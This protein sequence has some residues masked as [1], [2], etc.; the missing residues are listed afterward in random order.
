MKKLPKL[1]NNYLDL[2]RFLYVFD[3]LLGVFMIHDLLWIYCCPELNGASMAGESANWIGG[4]FQQDHPPRPQFPAPVWLAQGEKNKV[5]S[6]NLTVCQ[7]EN[8]HRNSGFT[9]WKLWFSIVN[10]YVV[11]YQA[12]YLLKL[13]E[14]YHLC[15][16]SG[17][18]FNTWSMWLQL[19]QLAMALCFD[20]S[21]PY[22]YHKPRIS[23]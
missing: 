3:W 1:G 15:D 9:H 20:L 8:G 14:F 11:V 18:I 19:A 10:S 21:P 6:G 4:I 7:L 23:P 12:G 16:K 17:S 5:P 13:I 22:L 2:V